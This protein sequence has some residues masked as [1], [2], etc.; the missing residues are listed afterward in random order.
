MRPSLVSIL[1]IALL[2]CESAFAEEDKKVDANYSLPSPAITAG[3][4][5]PLILS[6]AVG[7]F[8]PLGKHDKDNLFPTVLSLRFDGEVGLGGGSAAV[9]MYIPVDDGSFAINLKAVRMRTWL[10]T[11]D[12]ESNSTFDG[13]VVELV[14]LGHVPGKIGLGFFQDTAFNNKHNSFT[15]V[16]VGVGW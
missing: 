11:L 3:F 14:V 7:A 2:S 8:L 1:V 10:L 4:S 5:Y 13:G 15:Y 16:F 9:G 12:V 6:G